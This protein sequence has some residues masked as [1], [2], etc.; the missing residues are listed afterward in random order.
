M[1]E[2][3]SYHLHRYNFVKLKKFILYFYERSSKNINGFRNNV[4]ILANSAGSGPNFSGFRSGFVYRASGPIIKFGS[5][6][7]K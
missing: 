7:L 3:N 2:H 5:G 4:L 1:D 6:F